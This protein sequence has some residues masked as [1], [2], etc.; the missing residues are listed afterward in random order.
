ML[1]DL[2]A[3]LL[4]IATIATIL[5]TPQQDS[6]THKTVIQRDSQLTVATAVTKPAGADKKALGASA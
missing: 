1:N 3:R 4:A 6:L 2:P 5:N